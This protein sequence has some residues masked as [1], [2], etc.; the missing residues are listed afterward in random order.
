MRCEVLNRPTLIE[1]MPN[2][3]K[4][5]FK[6]FIY[7]LKQTLTERQVDIPLFLQ[8]D[9][10]NE[11]LDVSL[12]YQKCGYKIIAKIVEIFLNEN[13]QLDEEKIK[14]LSYMIYIKNIANWNNI[15]ESLTTKYNILDSKKETKTRIPNL[16]HDETRNI[17]SKVT[18]INQVSGYNSE[19]FTNLNQSI[20]SG[21][22]NDNEETR[23]TKE[24]GNENIEISGSD[25]PSQDLILKE[26]DLRTMNNFYDIILKSFDDYLTLKIWL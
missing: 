2:S 11:M 15:F 9:E 19:D 6:G 5:D 3:F 22:M 26:L 1:T 20:N 25:I 10:T 16:Q 7:Y 23:I 21:E 18:N 17:K 13:N 4:Q 8:S 14:S 12:I 24:T